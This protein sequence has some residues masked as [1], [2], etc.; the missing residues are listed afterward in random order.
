VF[1]STRCPI[2]PLEP[3]TPI[4]SL[5]NIHPTRM[6]RRQSGI[7]VQVALLPPPSLSVPLSICLSILRARTPACPAICSEQ[8]DVAVIKLT[9]I[10]RTRPPHCELRNVLAALLRLFRCGFKRSILAIIVDFISR[11]IVTCSSLSLSFFCYE[12]VG[13]ARVRDCRFPND[14]RD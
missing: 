1:C 8:T 2:K 10:N 7:Q 13:I 6:H 14:A 4:K 9:L 11:S 5:L 3:V 12:R